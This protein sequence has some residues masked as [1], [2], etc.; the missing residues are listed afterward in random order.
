METK[1]GAVET[2]KVVELT[3]LSQVDLETFESKVAEKLSSSDVFNANLAKLKAS[4][5]FG[6]LE[7]ELTAKIKASIAAEQFK[8]SPQASKT[9]L[10]EPSPK[11]Q[12]CEPT[13][14]GSAEKHLIVSLSRE[15][16]QFHLGTRP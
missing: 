3:S 2:G 5:E 4:K 10:E 12:E 6:D 7:Q 9:V 13:F 11:V 14:V 15:G 16:T 1:I 8:D